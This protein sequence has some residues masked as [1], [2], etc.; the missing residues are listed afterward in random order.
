MSGLQRKNIGGR[1]VVQIIICNP[2][3]IWASACS[4][5]MAFRV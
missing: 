5:K 1:R 4:Q 3:K 2:R